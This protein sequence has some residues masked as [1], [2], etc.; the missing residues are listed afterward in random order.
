MHRLL[1]P[2]MPHRTRIICGFIV[3]VLLPLA[4]GDNG[5]NANLLHSERLVL[6]NTQREA[7]PEQYKGKGV[8]YMGRGSGL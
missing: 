8:S 3:A 7:S 1:F 6:S 4:L 2:S 5:K